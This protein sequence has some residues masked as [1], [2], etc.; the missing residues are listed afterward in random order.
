MAREPVDTPKPSEFY[1]ACRNDDIDF[2]Q[3]S[4]TESSLE[5]LD[6]VEPN[7]STALHAACYFK[8]MGIVRLLLDRGFTRCVTN[9]YRNRPYDECKGEE[10]QRLFLRPTH[11]DRF[12][13]SV[14]SEHDKQ[15]WL[16]LDGTEQYTMPS[17][18]LDRYDGNRLEYGTFHGE[19]ILQSL[20]KSMANVDVIQ[21]LFRRAVEEKDCTRLIQAYTTDTEFHNRVNDYLLT[22]DKQ[23]ATKKDAPVNEMSEFVDT[24]F[25]NHEMHQKYAFVG[26]CYRTIQLKADSDLELYRIGTKF[27]NRTFIS[28]TKDRHFAE[29]YA[30]ARRKDGEYVAIISLDIEQSGTALDIEKI[31]E[32][33]D[34]KEILIMNNHIFKVVRV[35]GTT[36]TDIDIEF[37]QSKSTRVNAKAKNNSV[38]RIFHSN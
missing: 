29:K 8:H 13:G 30:R 34:E 27:V 38:P 15:L 4:L 3:R 16:V 2:V 5:E 32:F 22:R 28:A 35:S 17:R 14:S 31:S 7:G 1:F 11:S 24:I 33:P 25:F 26:K 10:M 19:K 6:R 18:P 37:R 23:D 21:R 20:N 36:T 12:G 9:R